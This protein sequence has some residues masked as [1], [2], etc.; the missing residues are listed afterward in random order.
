MD[1][2]LTLLD[3]AAL[4]HGA[5]SKLIDLA[6]PSRT[7]SDSAGCFHMIQG[8]IPMYQISAD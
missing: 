1:K 4:S 5:A 3:T 2:L 7:C 8:L 6:G